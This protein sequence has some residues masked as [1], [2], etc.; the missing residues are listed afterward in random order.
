ME[1]LSYGSHGLAKK[2]MNGCRDGLPNSCL[3]VGY[4]GIAEA[5]QLAARQ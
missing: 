1:S 5:L 4:H 3:S 2:H